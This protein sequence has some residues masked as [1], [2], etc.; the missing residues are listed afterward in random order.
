MHHGPCVD[1]DLC[2]VLCL[3]PPWA[4]VACRA[5]PCAAAAT[6][7]LQIR[8]LEMN[9]YSLALHLQKATSNGV[10]SSHRGPDVF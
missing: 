4:T 6:A 1:A 10:L 7:A 9:N 8:T 2:A 5:M 3:P